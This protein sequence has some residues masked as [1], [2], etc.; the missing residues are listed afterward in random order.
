LFSIG[1][2]RIVVATAL[3]GEGNA[4]GRVR[5]FVFVL[6]FRPADLDIL[7]VFGS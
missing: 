7:R 1:V 6:F 5:P 2:P 4:I 3:S